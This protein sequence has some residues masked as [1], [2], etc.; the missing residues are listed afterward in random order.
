MSLPVSR[1]RP[2]L[3]IF[4]YGGG[5]LKSVSAAF[6]FLG[7]ETETTSRPSGIAAAERLVL[8]GVGAF[9][10]CVRS[11]R[12]TGADTALRE[13]IASGRPYLGICVGLQVLFDRSEE[14][15]GA[16]GLGVFS[17][18]VVRF[19]P[20]GGL[21]VPHMGWN[22]L[23][24]RGGS[25]LFSGIE[26]GSRFYFAHSFHAPSGR[27]PVAATARHG[28]EFTAA[29]SGGNVFACQFHP[30]KSSD[31]GL[32]VMKNFALFQPEG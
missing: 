7:F 3:T 8:P 30:E 27:G 32:R 29:V 21:K 9:G 15:P 25:P 12:K 28:T 26:N 18:G 1:A 4:D 5:N 10:D 13:F 23:A 22:R 16:A 11:L 2:P 6:G 20:S 31:A 14:S 17:G 24:L 19:E